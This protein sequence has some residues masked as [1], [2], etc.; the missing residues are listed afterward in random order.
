MK[1]DVS[2]VDTAVTDQALEKSLA[3]DSTLDR[4]DSVAA[5]RAAGIKNL[6]PLE[7]GEAIDTRNVNPEEVIK[8]A[9]TL[10]GTPYVYGS[11]DPKVGFD[12]SGFIT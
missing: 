7:A 10:V 1:G 4:K 11:T 3:I 8:Y 2:M 9:E 6:D 5:S 12:C